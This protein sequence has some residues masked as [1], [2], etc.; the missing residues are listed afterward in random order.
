M[1]LVGEHRKLNTNLDQLMSD[2]LVI[3]T[4]S[5]NTKSLATTILIYELSS[6]V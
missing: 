5:E 1:R 2:H 3:I 4:V 6:R